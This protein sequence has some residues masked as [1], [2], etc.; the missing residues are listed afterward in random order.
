MAIIERNC[1]RRLQRIPPHLPRPARL[2]FT[3]HSPPLFTLIFG[4]A[5]E[6]TELTGVRRLLIDRDQ[7]PRTARFI[8][9]HLQGQNVSLEN[10]S[11]RLSG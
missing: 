2:A 7:T 10:A 5:F 1:K 8:E 4:H 11:A 6:N 9:I 3:D